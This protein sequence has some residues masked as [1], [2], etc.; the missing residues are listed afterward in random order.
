MSQSFKTIY[1]SD[2]PTEASHK[3][4]LT[5]AFSSKD[6]GVYEAFRAL[7][8]QELREILGHHT[9]ETLHRAAAQEGVAVNTY[10]LR[11]LRRAVAEVSSTRQPTRPGLIAAP[12]HLF[13]PIQTTFRGGQSEPLHDWY[14]Y[15]EGYSPQF[16]E[17]V[18]QEFAPQATRVLDPFAGTGTTPLT[19]AKLGR[20]AFYCELNPLL[21]YLIEVKTS[22]LTADDVTRQRWSAHLRAIADRLQISLTDAAPDEQLK[23]TYPA[24]FGDSKFFD[25]DI[26]NEILRARTFIDELACTEPF[27]ARFVA[28]A[29]LSSLLPASRLIRR[30]DVRFK[31]VAELKRQSEK[32][33]PAVQKLLHLIAADLERFKPI[34]QHP[35]LVCENARCLN[36]IPP[37]ETDAIITSPPYLNG[38]N[39]FRN[40]KVELW[41]LRCLRKASDLTAFRQ[42]TITAGI[43]DVTVG[44][45]LTGG[46]PDS[47]A[48]LVAR[49]KE[50][51][52]DMRIPLMVATYFADMDAV[53]KGLKR[54]LTRDCSLMIDIGDSVYGGVHV[55]THTLLT[56]LLTTQGFSFEREIVLRRR[57]SRSG[58]ALQQ[59]LLVF[60]APRAARARQ[61]SPRLDVERSQK[62]ARFKAALPHQKGEYARR[63][64]GHPLHSL[65]S[66][67]GKMKP[68][69]AHYLVK[70]FVPAGGRMLDVFGGT[71]TIPFEA[72]L[73]GA[74]AWSFDISPAAHHISSAKL[75]SH[76]PQQCI[77]L[78]DSLEEFLCV[79][80]IRQADI[81][82]A[83]EIR[84][85][86]ALP[87]YFSPETFKE[88]ILARRYFSEHQPRTPSESLV[89]AA[90]LHIL[91]GNRPYALSR[92]SHPIT[93]FA[94]SGTAEYRSL[95]KSLRAKVNRSLTLQYPA[96]FMPGT[97]LM[98]DATSWWPQEINELDVIITSPPFFDS[99]R[100]YL[101][102][103]MRLWFCGWEWH[104]FKTQPLAYVDERQKT[105]FQIYK[106]IFR[107]AR[108]RLKTDGVFV[109]HLGESRKCDMGESLRQAASRWFNV[110]DL[111]S[112]S[113]GHCES[114]GIR[115][116][117]T[118]T[119]HQYLVLH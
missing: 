6:A 89:F 114:H 99:T 37:L 105:G 28:V 40:T 38:T 64:W 91:H 74:R 36:S 108:E 70:T 116:K 39:Y 62:W 61:G 34:T 49:L 4:N 14:P 68:S 2:Y 65:C 57:M 45:S 7:S 29:V 17:Q 115:D 87:D 104:S 18:L 109:L 50:T 25:D 88:I 71:G 66:Y 13:E 72:A 82:A 118:V 100:F 26:F 48:T 103:W 94:P 98:Q 1:F 3:K 52:Y 51:A 35:V 80:R 33:I 110:I 106:P 10:C 84:F 9:Y 76:D 117:G 113:V 67:Q 19:A 16:V 20:R 102:N 95:M 53:C 46:L 58:G 32:L 60:R 30:G 47:I 42:R 24:T 111:F 31:T 56:E 15:L 81:D 77:R 8:S 23:E 43:N 97:A 63:N 75:G 5:L 101:A 112:E 55:P 27:V 78:M 79:G 85:N 90:L 21:Q 22:A 69:L 119:S 44:K 107:Q 73:R 92:R 59:L 86:G 93:P 12:P 11:L 54:H 41:F 83:Q 96:E